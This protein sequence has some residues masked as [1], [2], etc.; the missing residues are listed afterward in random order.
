MSR[1]VW[2]D[3]RQRLKPID[4]FTRFTKSS[5]LANQINNFPKSRHM[6]DFREP[7]EALME[8]KFTIKLSEFVGF[9]F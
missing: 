2:F 3:T 4:V 5:V 1:N 9:S 7:F 8:S 6:H